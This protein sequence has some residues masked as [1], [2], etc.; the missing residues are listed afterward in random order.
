MWHELYDQVIWFR[1]LLTQFQ[2]DSM[3]G[4]TRFIYEVAYR[5]FDDMGLQGHDRDG[6]KWAMKVMESEALKWLNKPA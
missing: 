2:R 4:A 6:W 3:G 1:S 5:D